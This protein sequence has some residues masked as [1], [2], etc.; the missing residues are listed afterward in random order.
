MM[1]HDPFLRALWDALASASPC[2][3][4]KSISLSQVFPF[5]F[6]SVI[7]VF[8]HW[9]KQ[10]P[11]KTKK[12]WFVSSIFWC[13]V[14]LRSG[15]DVGN[16][17]NLNR[18]DENGCSTNALGPKPKCEQV[19]LLVNPNVSCNGPLATKCVA[20]GSLKNNQSNERTWQRMV[21]NE[22]NK[23]PAAHVSSGEALANLGWRETAFFSCNFRR[24]LLGA[25]NFRMIHEVIL[26]GFTYPP[27]SNSCK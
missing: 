27:L 8:H 15:L 6:G 13:P 10:Q 17:S 12:K 25:A 7:Q 20:K 23:T 21:K 5:C 16:D 18:L 1:S 22:K 9:I 3:L 14:F 19:H 2:L 26:F 4:S 11:K 24:S